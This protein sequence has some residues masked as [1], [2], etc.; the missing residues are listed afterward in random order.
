MKFLQWLSEYYAAPY[1]ATFARAAREEDDLF[2]MLT[3]SEA[4]G[5]P[6]PVG[7]YTLELL[8]LVYED[9]HRWHLRQGMESSPF[10]GISCC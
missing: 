7:F 10:E 4:F 5:V 2:L 6:N 8:P 1:R 9:L 3:V